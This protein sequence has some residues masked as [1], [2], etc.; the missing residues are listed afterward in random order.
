[1]ELVNQTAVPAKLTVGSTDGGP[2]RFGI[3]VAK[4]TFALAPGNRV[5]LVTQDPYPLFDKDQKTEFGLLPADMAPRRDR[6]FEVIVLGAAYGW[7]GKELPSRVVELSVGDIT[8]RLAVFGDRAWEV[9][10]MGKRIPAPK[11][12]QKMPLTY[13]RA[14]GGSR[15]VKLDEHTIFDVEDRINKHG[16]GFDAE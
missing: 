14:F 8:R 3:L 2:Q 1:M 10:L 13:D 15:P 16:K 7:N 5:E 6:A 11:P 12:F 9:T 4:A